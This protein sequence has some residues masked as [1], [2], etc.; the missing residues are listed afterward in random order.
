MK[1]E[2]FA[3]T[4][5]LAGV[6][7]ALST[8]LQSQIKDQGIPVSYLFSVGGLVFAIS[9]RILDSIIHKIMTGSFYNIKKSNFWSNSKVKWINIMGLILR[10]VLIKSLQILH[11]YASNY[12]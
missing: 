5:F 1:K 8:F 10:V 3:K 4:S 12:A 9:F 2:F 6:L 11:D 7:K